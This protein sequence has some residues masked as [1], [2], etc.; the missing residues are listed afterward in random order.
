M[1]LNDYAY[2][3]T[4]T[5]LIENVIYCDDEVAPTL[6]WPEGYAIVDIP[7]GGVPGEWSTCGIG[8]FY[9]NGQFVEP[10]EPIVET[11]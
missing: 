5:G 11:A 1:T 2:Y 6:V 4:Q 3:N 8:W 7:T 10:P 9:I